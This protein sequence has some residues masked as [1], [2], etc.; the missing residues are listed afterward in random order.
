MAEGGGG[1]KAHLAASLSPRLISKPLP[2]RARS[3]VPAQ[4]LAAKCWRQFGVAVLRGESP[5]GQA[6]A[7]AALWRACEAMTS[8]IAHALSQY[9]RVLEYLSRYGIR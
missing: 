3:G 1:A 8:T 7:T 2:A 4:C 5:G 6:P 9:K